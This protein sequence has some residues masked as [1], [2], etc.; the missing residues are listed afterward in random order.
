MKKEGITNE[1]NVVENVVSK[2][3]STIQPVKM[4]MQSEELEAIQLR[5]T[6]M[7]QETS[8]MK[9]PSSLSVPELEYHEL[10]LRFNRLSDAELQELADDIEKNGLLEEIELRDGKILDGINRY[11]ALRLKGVDPETIRRKHCKEY[12]GTNPA[13]FVLSKNLHRRHL[14]LTDS[15][16]AMLVADMES[17]NHGG[18]R[19]NQDG[20]IHVETREE[21][22]KAADVSPSLVA[23][24]KK[25][26]ESSPDDA[27][28]IRDGKTT[29]GTVTKSLKQIAKSTPKSKMS[30]N[31]DHTQPKLLPD[32]APESNEQVSSD[33][34]P[35][36]W[37]QSTK[38]A[39]WHNPDKQL[40]RWNRGGM[41]TPLETVQYAID[42][43]QG[44][45]D[46][47]VLA[48]L[49]AALMEIQALALAGGT[50]LT[51]QKT[52]TFFVDAASEDAMCLIE[53]M[54]YLVEALKEVNRNVLR[55]QG[56]RHA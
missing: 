32:N 47:N 50:E 33:F 39:W 37:M 45:I 10:A 1:M 41:K 55:L 9:P 25:I 2:M 52:D 27:Q 7:E 56:D 22:A 21:L 30:D 19:K 8:S 18:N 43:V 14:N 42:D 26:K 38:K 12:L 48:K 11:L 13:A 34:E 6:D 23:R 3:I 29:V 31:I 28:D 15:Q 46:T 54:E 40:Y 44:A 49:L 4:P 20:S 35:G 51:E 5:D 36:E 53:R 16:R 24:A 17:Y